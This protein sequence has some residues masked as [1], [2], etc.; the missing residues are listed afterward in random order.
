[1]GGPTRSRTWSDSANHSTYREVS[2]EISW[3]QK[4]PLKPSNAEEQK[5]LCQQ[6]DSGNRLQKTSSLCPHAWA[7]AAWAPSSCVS[8]RSASLG[9]ETLFASASLRRWHSN[10]T[11]HFLTT[12]PGSVC[13]PHQHCR[14]G[15]PFLHLC[16]RE[17]VFL[18]FYFLSHVHGDTQ[19]ICCS[20][21]T[22]GKVVNFGLEVSINL[23]D[24][25][26]CKSQGWA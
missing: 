25:S 7:A 19:A 15:N 14:E 23:H 8:G 4:V 16:L 10:R 20:P 6:N 26:G 24:R 22:D 21:H 9:S 12:M 18:F 13:R 1:M 11:L 17:L 5:H 2:R 3:L